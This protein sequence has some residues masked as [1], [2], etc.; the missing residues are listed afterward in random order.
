MCMWHH[1]VHVYH[2]NLEFYFSFLFFGFVFDWWKSISF[3]S[4]LLCV[5]CH[6][7]CLEM[8]E[9]ISICRFRPFLHPSYWFVNLHITKPCNFK[10]CATFHRISLFFSLVSFTYISLMKWTN[11]S[12]ASQTFP[13][14]LLSHDFSI[15]LYIK[16]MHMFFE[17][18]KWKFTDHWFA[19]IR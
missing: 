14:E 11:V 1:F 8:L 18:S 10:P 15:S 17:I 7:D 9:T 4:I 2:K 6:P 12:I 13:A 16:W 3:H 19:L 5:V